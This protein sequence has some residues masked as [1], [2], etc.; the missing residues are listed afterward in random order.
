MSSEVPETSDTDEDPLKLILD[1]EHFNEVLNACQTT[2][3]DVEKTVVFF[4]AGG[5]AYDEIGKRLNMTEKSVDNALQRAR[6][7]LKSV[8][9]D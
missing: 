2:L 6:R 1:G 3:S 8:C 5:M 9:S 7:K 4:R